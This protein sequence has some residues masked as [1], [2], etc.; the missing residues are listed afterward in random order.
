MKSMDYRYIEQLLERYWEAQ[1]SVEEESILRAFFRQED[2]PAHLASYAPLFV[3]QEKAS[4]TVAGESLSERLL[5]KVEEIEGESSL[6]VVYAQ[7]VGVAKRFMPLLRAASVVAVVLL[8]SVTA[9]HALHQTDAMNMQEAGVAVEHTN[10]MTQ[11]IQAYEAGVNNS[12]T[13]V[14]EKSSMGIIRTDSINQDST[15]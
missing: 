12:K 9:Q 4:Q 14:N 7:R 11:P 3:Y 2:I 5:R 8:V 6:R 10:G 13:V 1:T 15:L